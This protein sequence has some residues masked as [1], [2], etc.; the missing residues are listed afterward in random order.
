MLDK[1]AKKVFSS[2][3]GN[4]DAMVFANAVD[5]H[6]DLSFFYLTGISEGLFEGSAAVALPNGKVKVIT[7]PLEATTAKRSKCEVIIYDKPDEYPELLK[8]AIEG[9][10]NVGINS[11][12]LTVATHKKLKKAFNALDCL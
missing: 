3:K 6:L 5:P 9:A 11:S 7:G 12:E 8:E 1:R 10:T 4:V 2:Y